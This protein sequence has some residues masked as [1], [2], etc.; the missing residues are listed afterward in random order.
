MDFTAKWIFQGWIMLVLL[1]QVNFYT[2]AV[3]I[4]PSQC[5]TEREY[6]QDGKCC[7]KCK[8][9]EY[10]SARCTTVSDTDCKPCGE[11]Q[12]QPYWNTDNRC[13]SQ[14]ICDKERGLQ[15]SQHENKTAPVKCACM[16]GFQC[17][18]MDCEFCERVRV[19]GPG[20]GVI[21]GVNTLNNLCEKCPHGSF[22]AVSSATEPC[23]QWTDCKSLGK[24]EVHHGNET[25]D[26]QCGPTAT[27]L[28]NVIICVVVVLLII[29]VST[30]GVCLVCNKNK[31]KGISED[32]RKI[33][34][35]VNGRTQQETTHPKENDS[36]LEVTLLLK[37][38]EKPC[39]F[40]NTCSTSDVLNEDS[41]PLEPAAG[42]SE[43]VE[44]KTEESALNSEVDSA[45][46]GP[47]PLASSS[48]SS[49]SC[50]SHLKRPVEAGEQDDFSQFVSIGN[51][52]SCSCANGTNSRP[53]S[54]QEVCYCSHCCGSVT[55][56]LD[57]EYKG[58]LQDSPCLSVDCCSCTTRE[59]S[60]GD[61]GPSFGNQAGKTSSENR[62][63]GHCW[64]S[65]DSMNGPVQSS[66]T[67]NGEGIPSDDC[68]TQTQNPN[69]KTPDPRSNSSSH[70]S[71]PPSAS[72]N[73][74]G[75]KNTTFISNGQV[76]NFSGD[77]IVV[78]VSQNS[79][80]S[81]GRTEETFGCPVQEENSGGISE[82]D[83]KQ[84]QDDLPQV[85]IAY[86]LQEG[87]QHRK[88]GPIR[89]TTIPIQEE[90]TQWT[91]QKCV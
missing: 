63:N 87:T 78:Y 51:S 55:G 4:A 58:D 28:G 22:S 80:T 65:M 1:C 41:V 90:S 24:T 88:E 5:N 15:A 83:T 44:D 52:V 6:L 3:P 20:Y 67:D 50:V 2:K 14:K 16:P 82:D 29:L 71:D 72:G 30:F 37:N 25:V 42:C 26:V 59:A 81:T 56:C 76:M 45:S 74:T 89:S 54:L 40:L 77:V 53:K 39:D 17:A 86:P 9:G 70:N 11:K 13:M 46:H 75:N 57:C 91:Q 68:H 23:K 73:M 66:L 64:C 38:E 84:E 35:N 33:Y 7:R 47:A 62:L 48:C 10:L 8:P 19:C 60:L 32:F 85:N 49:C 43:P 79:Q 27:A 21:Q 61:K 31:M 69:S 18:I 36:F 12:Y 34:T